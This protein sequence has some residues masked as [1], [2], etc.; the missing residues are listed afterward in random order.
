MRVPNF[1][2]LAEDIG[3]SSMFTKFVS[4]LKYLAICSNT[5]GSKS[6]NVKNEAKFACFPPVKIR[7][8]MGETSGSINEASLTTEPPEY[9]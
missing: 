3:Q 8:G 5:G 9:I 4:E 2:K 7:G 1:T 6:S